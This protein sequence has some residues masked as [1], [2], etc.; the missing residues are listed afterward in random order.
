MAYNYLYLIGSLI[1][2]MFVLRFFIP[3]LI[4]LIPVFVIVYFIKRIMNKK[5][6]E[7]EEYEY[8]ETNSSSYNAQSDVIDVDYKVVDVE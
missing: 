2:L 8:Y 1:L 7:K 5:K 3:L 4:C 6:E